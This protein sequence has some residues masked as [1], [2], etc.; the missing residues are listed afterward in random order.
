MP[1]GEA[2][3]GDVLVYKRG[4]GGHVALYV[5]EDDTHYHLL[6]GNQSDS[7]NIVRK[8][9]SP[10]GP[11]G[12]LAVRRAPWRQ[13]QPPNVRKVILSPTGAPVSTSEA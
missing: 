9:R 12:L 6:G 7:V 3:L 5:G 13:M 10:N 4:R 8:T 2:M 11:N 1:L